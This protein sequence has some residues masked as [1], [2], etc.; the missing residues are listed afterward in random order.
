[1]YI[2]ENAEGDKDIKR[3]KNAVWV[4]LVSALLWLVTAVAA[5]GYWWRHRERHS[6]FTGR[7]R[8]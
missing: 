2:R 4:D 8:V 6:R 7:A 5:F 1:M 3:M